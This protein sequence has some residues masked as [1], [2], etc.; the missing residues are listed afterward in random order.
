VPKGP[1]TVPG[2]PAERNL[3]HPSSGA[4]ASPASMAPRPAEQRAHRQVPQ[5]V[6]VASAVHPLATIPATRKPSSEPCTRHSCPPRIDDLSCSRLADRRSGQPLRFGN[7]FRSESTRRRADPHRC[8]Q[9]RTRK[10]AHSRRSG[11]VVSRNGPGSQRRTTGRSVHDRDPGPCRPW[12]Y[13]SASRRAL[14]LSVAVTFGG[15][16][17]VDS[18]RSD[19]QVL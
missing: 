6:H 13:R 18:M 4:A 2:L 7:L 9:P 16:I 8:D 1:A 12:K 5:Q 19:C 14:S 3:A 11:R 17:P 15:R 10:R